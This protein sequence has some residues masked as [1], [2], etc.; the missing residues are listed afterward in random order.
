[1]L[2]YLK[3]VNAK[4]SLAGSSLRTLKKKGG[5]R[6]GMVTKVSSK[7]KL[8]TRASPNAGVKLTN[9]TRPGGQQASI[10]AGNRIPFKPVRV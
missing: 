1:L 8:E 10:D 2:A 3:S 4:I 9:P 7:E 5:Q 6:T